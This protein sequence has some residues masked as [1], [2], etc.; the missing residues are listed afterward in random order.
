LLPL[1]SKDKSPS[2]KIFEDKKINPG[3]VKFSLIELSDNGNILVTYSL[4]FKL[5]NYLLA[6]LIKK[7]LF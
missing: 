5:S 6:K 3:P 2:A 4:I 1:I 7:Q